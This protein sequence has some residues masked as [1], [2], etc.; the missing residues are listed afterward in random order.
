MAFVPAHPLLNGAIGRKENEEENDE[1]HKGHGFAF[2]RFF[3][4]A[5]FRA[6]SVA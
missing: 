6:L 4:A 5:F 3:A 1:S 2:E